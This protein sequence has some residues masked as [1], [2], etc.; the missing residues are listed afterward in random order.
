MSQRRPS[1][2][3][4][5]FASEA[6]RAS[7]AGD[8]FFLHCGKSVLAPAPNRFSTALTAARADSPDRG[9]SHDVGR[10]TSYDAMRDRQVTEPLTGLPRSKRHNPWPEAR[11]TR[12]RDR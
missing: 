11:N 2:I 6:E 10:I 8:T 12:T 9:L 3:A 4:L 5:R 1:H 7:K